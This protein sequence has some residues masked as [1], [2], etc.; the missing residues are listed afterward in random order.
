MWFAHRT[1]VMA[2]PIRAHCVETRRNCKGELWTC[3]SHG[4]I[5]TDTPHTANLSTECFKFWYLYSQLSN[6][7]FFSTMCCPPPS[8][9]SPMPRNLLSLAV[10]SST[11]R[12]PHSSSLPLTPLQPTPPCLPNPWNAP[13]KK[14]P[15]QT[16]WASRLAQNYDETHFQHYTYVAVHPSPQLT[17]LWMPHRND[18]RE[19][20][21]SH[22]GG[23][24]PKRRN[25]YD[26]VPNGMILECRSV[27]CFWLPCA[28]SWSMAFGA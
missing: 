16:L 10:I 28:P 17:L 11:R 5:W 21:V 20:F 4:P 14:I 1:L 6:S 24:S 8:S 18:L 2:S 27:K 7:I 13:K 9:P 25:K 12:T 19:K 15:L 22:W 3:Y 26:I 23:E